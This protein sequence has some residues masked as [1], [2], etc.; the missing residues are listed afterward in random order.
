MGGQIWERIK[1]PIIV[2]ELIDHL[3]SEYNVKKDECE[4]QVLS[5]LNLL[6]KEEL[7]TSKEIVNL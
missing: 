7:I 3:L 2:S 1:E 6:L 4:R 5:F